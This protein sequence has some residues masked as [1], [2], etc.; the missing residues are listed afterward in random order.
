MLTLLRAVYP[1]RVFASLRLHPLHREAGDR[2][3]R[4]RLMHHNKINVPEKSQDWSGPC[5][6]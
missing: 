4:Q 5:R 1:L 2:G 3:G 6:R